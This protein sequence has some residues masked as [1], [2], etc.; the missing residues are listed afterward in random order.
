MARIPCTMDEA[1]GDLP[2]EVVNMLTV[3]TWSDKPN[4]ADLLAGMKPIGWRVKDYA[5]GWINVS[6]TEEL[7]LLIAAMG[8]ALVEAVW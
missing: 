2:V 8:T 4:A 5:D 7:M 6:S 1:G 3:A